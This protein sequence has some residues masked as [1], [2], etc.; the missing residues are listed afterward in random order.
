MGGATRRDFLNLLGLGAVILL[1]TGFSDGNYVPCIRHGNR[2][3][4]KVALTFDD[5]WDTNVNQWIINTLNRYDAKATFF[6]VGKP[7]E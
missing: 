2:D 3:S 4:N 7:L 5:G 1:T 6:V